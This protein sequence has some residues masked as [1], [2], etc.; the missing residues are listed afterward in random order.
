MARKQIAPAFSARART[1]SSGK[2]VMKMN[3]ARWPWVRM[4]VSR[5]RPL[6][7]GICTSAITQEVPFTW[8]DRRNSS[9]DANVCTV[10][11]CD[12]RRLLVAAR[13]DASSSMTDM[14]ESVDK[15]GLSDAGTQRLL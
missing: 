11:P 2:A 7:T 4:S 12:L 6:R 1:L 13:T 8:A 3:G 9:A 10:Y 5:S 14:T 15:A